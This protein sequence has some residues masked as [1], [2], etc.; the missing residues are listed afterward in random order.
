MNAERDVVQ[1][2]PSKDGWRWRRRAV[3]GLI[4][5]ESGEGYDDKSHARHMA[6]TRNP[7]HVP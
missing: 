5:A 7:G 2:Y 3:N 4:V 6:E 1:V